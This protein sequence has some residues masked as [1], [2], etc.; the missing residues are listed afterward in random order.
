MSSEKPNVLAA[1]VGSECTAIERHEFSWSFVFGPLA[2]HVECL[3]RVLANGRIALT[4][5]D[6][7]QQ[8]GL[9]APV[10]ALTEAQALLVGRQIEKNHSSGGDERSD[11]Y[12]Q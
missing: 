3:W 7:G 5:N 4:R 2:V 6:D 10:D 12:V 1:Y 9:P 11:A 8:F